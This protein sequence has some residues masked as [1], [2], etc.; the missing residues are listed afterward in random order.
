TYTDDRITVDLH[1]KSGPGETPLASYTLELDRRFSPAVRL[2]HTIVLPS[3]DKASWG[4]D[5]D[6][7]RDVVCLTEVRTPVGGVET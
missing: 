5:Y 4:L 6:K 2:P 1:P 7:V 3:D